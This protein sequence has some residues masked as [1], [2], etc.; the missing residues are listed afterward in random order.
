YIFHFLEDGVGKT[1]IDA[2]I[3]AP[4]FRPKNGAGV[5]DVAERPEAFVGETFVVAA[6][7]LGSEPDAAE[8]VGGTR[9]GNAQ[10]ILMIDYFAIG[11]AGT[12]GDPGAVAGVE[13]GFERGDDA[14]GG[15]DDLDGVVAFVE[16]VHVGLPI[17]DD[18]KR[19]VLQFIVEADAEAVRGPERGLRFAEL[20]FF[21]GGRARGG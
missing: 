13:H 5:G 14:A 11:V 2:L 7:F 17:G 20:R 1:L 8:S 15:D 6:I 4:I 9:R 21:L 16:D 18:V 3:F 12:V 10:V 19:V